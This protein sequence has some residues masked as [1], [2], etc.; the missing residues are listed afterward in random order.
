VRERSG[1]QEKSGV[2]FSKSVRGRE[3]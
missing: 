3:G 1:M 2:N